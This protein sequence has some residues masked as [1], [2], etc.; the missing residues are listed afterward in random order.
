[1]HVC[2]RSA[3]ANMLICSYSH[4]F[5]HTESERR[6]EGDLIRC[7]RVSFD[8]FD[9]FVLNCFVRLGFNCCVCVCVSVALA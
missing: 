5:K 7:H 2:I 6:G 3:N 9:I 4:H 1:M 8:Q